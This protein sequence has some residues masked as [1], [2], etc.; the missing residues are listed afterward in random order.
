VLLKENGLPE[1]GRDYRF[2]EI[3]ANRVEALREGR[4][5]ASMLNAGQERA[6][7]DLGFHVLDTI[8]HLYTNYANI[9]AVRRQWAN[10]HPE[11]VT[12]YLRAHMRAI[13]WLE[14]PANAAEAKQF[15]AYRADVRPAPGPPAFCWEGIREMMGTRRDA[16]LLRGPADPHRFA[17]ESYYLKAVQGL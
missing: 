15:P 17:D 9:G 2:E 11:V 14:N 10:E 8:D 13:Q 7:A 12:R 4:F 3:G 6:L 5:V 1:Y 16:G